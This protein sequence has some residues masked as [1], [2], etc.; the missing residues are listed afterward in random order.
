MVYVSQ[1]SPEDA[2][3]LTSGTA[4][5]LYMFLDLAAKRGDVTKATAVALRTGSKKVL[6]IDGDQQLDLR[7]LDQEDLLSRFHRLSKA[8]LNDQSRATYEGRFRRAVEMYLKYLDDDPTWKPVVSKARASTPKLSAN[9][10]TVPDNTGAIIPPRPG[11]TDFPVPLRP[12]VVAKLHLPD[13]LGP[14]EA[15]KIIAIVTALANEERLAI[16]A[17][18]SED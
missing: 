13:D 2:E 10:T 3:V 5:G 1:P 9:G 12:G 4:A 16:T 15:R 17:G 11:M 18:N 7:A 8:D 14:K 6:D